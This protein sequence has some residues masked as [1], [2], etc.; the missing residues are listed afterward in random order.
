MT[1]KKSHVWQSLVFY[2]TGMKWKVEVQEGREVQ[3]DTGRYRK[4]QEGRESILVSILTKF[5]YQ[6]GQPRSFPV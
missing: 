1:Q 3:E 5:S 4:I 6:Q 2:G